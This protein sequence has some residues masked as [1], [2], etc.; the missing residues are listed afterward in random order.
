MPMAEVDPK[1]LFDRYESFGI[2]QMATLPVEI[3]WQ[4]RDF[5]EKATLWRY[6]AVLSLAAQLPDA[7]PGAIFRELICQVKSWRRGSSPIKRVSLP[8]IFTP[9]AQF[10][11]IGIDSR[12]INSLERI[13]TAEAPI[14]DTLSPYYIV[15][16][17]EHFNG[18]LYEYID[19]LLRLQLP[20][21][22]KGFRIWDTPYRPLKSCEFFPKQ[23]DDSCYMRTINLKRT[24]GLT[25]FYGFD[26]LYAIHNHTSKHPS[27]AA[28][29]RG[30]LGSKMDREHKFWLFSPLAD[31]EAIEALQI[32]RKYMFLEPFDIQLLTSQNRA[33]TFSMPRSIR[34]DLVRLGRSPLTTLIYQE[35]DF[36]EPI[37]TIG[38]YNDDAGDSCHGASNILPKVFLRSN[39]PHTLTCGGWAFHSCAPLDNVSLAAIFYDPL[40]S[41][42]KGILL[43]Y[44]D[45]TRLALGQCGIGVFPEKRIVSPLMF[46]FKAISLRRPPTSRRYQGMLVDFS[47]ADTQASDWS[48]W[49]GRSMAGTANFWFNHRSATLTFESCEPNGTTPASE[50]P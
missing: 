23:P 47:S 10:L 4:I 41:F 46:Y 30:F 16:D 11:R 36:Y 1:V 15:E 33:S 13:T 29:F 3:L 26:S 24:A 35:P 12:G 8:P 44:L 48:D 19:G 6:A 34:G 37:P 17:E 2:P 9:T 14:V 40:R 27:A 50:S 5:S 32:Y 20:Q 49:E 45:D 21:G 7:D 18:V 28:T 22:H 38:V 43:H 39:S 25:F 31:N 42:C